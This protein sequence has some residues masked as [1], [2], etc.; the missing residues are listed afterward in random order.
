MIVD[1]HTHID[2][3]G[4]EGQGLAERLAE[5]E[6]VDKCFVLAGPGESAE[7]INRQL[8]EFINK[9]PA[10]MVGFGFADPVKD[11][12]KKTVS[13]L[14]EK[15]GLKGIV[16]YCSVCDFHP[17]HTRAMRLYEAAQEAGIVVFIHNGGHKGVSGS[18]KYAQP[19]LLDEIASEFKDLKIIIGNMGHP[20]VYQT[21]AVVANHPNVYADLTVR[22]DRPWQ[23]Y[24]TVIAAYE[25]ELL[26]KLLFGSGYP[27]GDAAASIEALLGFNK[28]LGDTNLPAVPRDELRKIVERDSAALLGVD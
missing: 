6:Q 23:L 4:K 14:K 19:Y 24:T 25:A 20:F 27:C 7:K 5:Q 28:R 8:S 3:P 17:G 9:Y 15:M 1:C 22:V 10:K 13:H 16:L 2:W 18:L 12:G 26:D 21:L 11:W